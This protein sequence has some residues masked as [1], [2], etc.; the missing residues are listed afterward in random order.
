MKRTLKLS[1]VFKKYAD[2]LLGKAKSGQAYAVLISDS[3]KQRAPESFATYE[4][5]NKKVIAL[6]EKSV[7]AAVVKTDP[8]AEDLSTGYKLYIRPVRGYDTFGS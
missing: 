8:H 7:G 5:A 4:E 2:I 1:D 3:D 6:H